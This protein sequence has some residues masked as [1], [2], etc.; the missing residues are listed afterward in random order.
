MK[1]RVKFQTPIR[2]GHAMTIFLGR[3][4]C[5]LLAAAATALVA[6]AENAGAESARPLQGASSRAI[7]FESPDVIEKLKV[8]GLWF[9][10]QMAQGS[11]LSGAAVFLFANTETG[12]TFSAAVNGV[13]LLPDDYWK[14]HGVADPDKLDVATLA[15]KVRAAGVVEIPL[16]PETRARV[17]DCSSIEWRSKQAGSKPQKCL[18]LGSAAVDIQDV[19]FSGT[20][21]FVFRQDGQ[22]QRFVAAYAIMQL[23]YDKLNGDKSFGKPLGKLDDFSEINITRKQIILHESGGACASATEFYSPDP[24]GESSM[25]LTRYQQTSTD[26]K[27][28]ACY[29]E[30]YAVKEQ[31]D[32]EST[33]F[34]LVSRKPA[35]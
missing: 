8:S 5:F 7:P 29:L 22:A 20:K 25:K 17:V 19:D 13:A 15:D 26:P 4:I 2:R 11:R 23:P 27:G 32:R 14:S 6:C 30:D 18:K 33:C 1:G 35:R 16:S 12:E 34:R 10:D 21:A 28:S 3:G 9:P 31:A 24:Q